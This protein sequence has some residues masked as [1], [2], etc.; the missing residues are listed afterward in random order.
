[1]EEK[2]NEIG[3]TQQRVRDNSKFCAYLPVLIRSK[4]YTVYTG[5]VRF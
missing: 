2:R 3:E 4:G 1:M 5:Q